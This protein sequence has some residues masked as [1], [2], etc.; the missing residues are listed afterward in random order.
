MKIAVLGANGKAGKLIVSELVNRNDDVTA[1]VRGENKSDAQNVLQKDAFS[2]TKEDLKG[3]DKV[4]NAL[5]FWTEEDLPK[6]EKVAKL[7]ADLLKGSNTELYV[8]GGAGSLYVDKVNGTQLYTT[9]DFPKEY[10]PVASNM[11]KGLE[12]LKN[13]SDLKWVYVSPAADF[14]PN[15]EKTGNYEITDDYFK[16][17]SNNQSYISYS[18]YA[19]GFADIVEGKLPHSNHLS[20]IQK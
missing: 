13:S 9:S 1:I 20:I 7:L 12:V 15:G 19:L 2:L 17:N 11:A 6:H 5:G 3:F 4:V 10:Y 18:D 14:D 16:L 8:V